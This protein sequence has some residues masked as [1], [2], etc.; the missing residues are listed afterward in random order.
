[1][2]LLNLLHQSVVLKF[3]EAAKPQ[4]DPGTGYVFRLVGVDAMGFLQ[5]Q[6]VR[7]GPNDEHETVCEPY[8]INKDLVLAILD[9]ASATGKD[10]LKFSGGSAP[11][12]TVNHEGAPAKPKR[13]AKAKAAVL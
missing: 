1:M 8:W 2:S 12:H 10:S 9:Y 4:Y 5:L 3:T 7:G 6:D 13:T 11:K